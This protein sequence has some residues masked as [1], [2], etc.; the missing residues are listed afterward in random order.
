MDCAP[1]G[2]FVCDCA[3][4]VTFANRAFLDV[5]GAGEAAV[6]GH[7]WLEAAHTSDRERLAGSWEN[8]LAQPGRWEAELRFLR[9]DGS[10]VE[11]H[12]M[13]SPIRDGA[14]VGGFVCSVKDISER[15]H[16][17]AVVRE[18][19]QRYRTVLESL[20]E[21]IVVQDAQ[22]NVIACN[23][24]APAILGLTRDQLLGRC[25]FDPA[26]RTT[27]ED[28]SPFPPDDY[29]V[30]ITARTGRSCS[31]VVMAVQKPDG[32]LSWISINTR[33]ICHAGGTTP[34]AVVASFVDI[35][36]RRAAGDALRQSLSLQRAVVESTADG[37]LVVDLEGRITSFNRR[38][39]E[40]WRIPEPVLSAHDDKLALQ[41]V[42]D[43][44][45]NPGAFVAKVEALYSQPDAESFDILEFKDGRVFERYSRAQRVDDRPVGRVWSFRDVSEQRNAGRER[46]RL[47]RKLQET[48]KLESLGV[49][50]GG[51]AHDFNNLLTGILG[52]AS[53]ARLQL[54]AGTRA[55]GHLDAVE[56]AA[57][58]AADLCKQMLAYAGKGRLDVRKV[59]LSVVVRESTDLLRLSI[60][61]K[62]EL[63]FD[64]PPSLPPVE[65][66]ATQLRQVVMNLVMNASDALADLPGVIRISTGLVHASRAYLAGV[67]FSAELA[68]GYYSFIEVTDTGCGM[69]RETLA[70]IFDPFFTTKFAG[71]G[72]GL[73]AVLGIV[74]GHEGTLKVTSEP[75]KGATFRLLLP[76]AGGVAPEAKAAPAVADHWH[77]QGRVLVV[78]D[79][80][81]VRVVAAHMLHLL[82][83]ETAPATDGR[84]ALDRIRREPGAYDVMLLDLTMPHLDGEQTLR[85][86]RRVRPDL[87]V[88]LMSGFNE[89]EATTRFSE[90]GL[91]GFLQKP[92]THDELRAQ[93]QRIVP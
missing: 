28:G 15:K 36:E 3:G 77:G 49:L 51:I 44:L 67:L 8:F 85:E 16:T 32:A 60:S 92:F 64:L 37:I 87:P 66:D 6:C 10:A 27:R 61:K 62:A 79:E 5:L 56:K 83:F 19:E 4:V 71:R 33:P 63:K 50:A 58:R 11:A 78:D 7:N 53:L 73:A 88:V 41:F 70:K 29:P 82:G 57:L 14:Q 23:E 24:S 90:H 9:P 91:A 20:A 47:E 2:L 86:V 81:S 84:D 80:D 43:Q 12:V 17:E 21:G 25:T 75:G 52:N 26:W 1:I 39:A 65:A 68:E 76:A 74:R 46:L 59:D 42:L 89:Q 55:A 38:F 54:P 22:G 69:S 45:T 13:A 40:M 35:T 34:Y 48:Q 93:L 31:N 18:S 30:T 72:L